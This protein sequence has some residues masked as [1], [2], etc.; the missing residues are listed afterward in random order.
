[1]PDK[2]PGSLISFYRR[3]TLAE[4]PTL[5]TNGA[6]LPQWLAGGV[7]SESSRVRVCTLPAASRREKR[8]RESGG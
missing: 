7:G 4:A 5:Y 6:M 8:K 2:F 3:D 1:M